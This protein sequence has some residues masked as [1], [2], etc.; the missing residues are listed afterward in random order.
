MI[1]ESRFK[2][3]EFPFPT[4]NT[5]QRNILRGI[6][7]MT[8]LQLDKDHHS[9]LDQDPSFNAKTNRNTYN[10]SSPSKSAKDIDD[11]ALESAMTDRQKQ[12]SMDMIG[13]DAEV[14]QVD[15]TSEIHSSRQTVTGAI[16]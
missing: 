11:E 9:I 16:I 4:P 10:N 14:D 8:K 5:N 1:D 6:S 12:P 2:M 7:S 13:S 3:V 15:Q